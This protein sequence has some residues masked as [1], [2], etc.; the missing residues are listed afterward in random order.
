[1]H[2]SGLHLYDIQEKKII[3]T[4]KHKMMDK[5]QGKKRVDCKRL[6]GIF[7]ILGKL[8]ILTVIIS[9]WIYLIPQ[10]KETKQVVD[11]ETQFI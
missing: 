1:M 3:L 11:L 6:R 7:D 8:S 5:A 4:K 2:I 10:I 9:T